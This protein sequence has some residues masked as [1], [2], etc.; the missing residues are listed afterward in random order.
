MFVCGA[1]VRSLED[2]FLNGVAVN[3]GFYEG[4]SLMPKRTYP[5]WIVIVISFLFASGFGGLFGKDTLTPVHLKPLLNK[6]A[7]LSEVRL[8]GDVDGGDLAAVVVNFEG[9][10]LKAD[11]GNMDIGKPYRGTMQ[12]VVEKD[13][14]PYSYHLFEVKNRSGLILGYLLVREGRLVSRYL[15]N[16]TIVLTGRDARL[17]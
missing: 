16:N 12:A 9:Q 15:E 4:R 5:R 3:S 11:S 7:R 17:P 8:V 2:D 1:A 6:V 14:K 10:N 13:F